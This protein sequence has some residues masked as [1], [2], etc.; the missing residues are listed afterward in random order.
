[1]SKASGSY[2]SLVRGVSQQ[3]P[4]D[5]Q[6]G[7]H[8]EMV[9]MIP[10]PVKGLSRRH[11][12]RWQAEKSLGLDGALIAAY[13]TDTANW[14]TFEYSNAGND[15]V[16]LVRRAA[17]PGSS[18]LHPIIG[19]NRTTKTFLSYSRNV[20][21]TVLDL[22][23]NGGVSAITA[24]GK[25]V[26][27]AGHTIV[28]HATS[29]DNWASTDNQ[30]NAVIW[31]RGGA[32]ART[33]KATVTKTDN[34][35]ASFEYTTP[36]ASYPGTLDTT[37]VPVWIPDTTGSTAGT[38]P[39]LTTAS[40]L[41]GNKLVGQTYTLVH[42]AGSPTSPLITGRKGSGDSDFEYRNLVN[43][44]DY[45][46]NSG[47][48]TITFLIDQSWD[49]LTAVYQWTAGGTS[50]TIVFATETTTEAAYIKLQTGYGVA[51]LVYK[52][53]NPTALTVHHGA[54]ALTNVSPAQPSAPSEYSWDAGGK[55]IVFDVS[56]VG[57]LLVSFAYTHTKVLT[58]PNYAK[59]VTDITNAF[60]T[61]VTNWIGTSAEAIQPNNIAESLRLAA[62]AAGM[63]GATRDASTI[64]FDNVK[65]V[66]VNDG[67]DGTL[68]RGVANE[69]ASID[70]VSDIHMIGKIVRIKARHSEEV[71]YLRAE[72]QDPAITS[73]Y[74]EVTWVEAAG[75]VHHID[76][77][78]VY[79]TVIG[80]TLHVASS[81]TLLNVLTSGDTPD[82]VDSTAGD[83]NSA[84][85]PFFI[86]RKIS[87][88]GV[89]QDRLVVGA[90]AVVRCSRIS[91][92]LNFFQSSIVTVL[93]NDPLE[94]LSQGSED[95]ELRYSALYDRDLVIFGKLRQYIISG[96]VALTPTSANMQVMSSLS[97][98]A[99]APPLAVANV[100]FYG[101]I[102]EKSS[103][104]HQIQ[105]GQ[106]AE[107]P[108]SFIN[109]SQID[110]YLTGS[111]IELCNHAKPT[112][113]FV[114]TSGARN[115]VFCFSYLEKVGE[116]RVQDAWGR[117]DF[118]ATLGPVIGMSRTPDGLLVYRLQ[119]GIK[120]DA[121]GTDTWVVADLCPLT[122]GL[123]LY[124][125]LDSIRP[126]SQ[127]ATDDQAV[128]SA[129]LGDYRIAFDSTSDFRFIGDV[130][131]SAD[132]LLAEFPDAT[133]PQVGAFQDSYFIPTNPFVRDRNDKAITQ[134][135]LTVTAIVASFNDTSGYQTEI[136]EG[137]ATE[138][139]LYNGRTMGDINDNIG[140]EPVTDALQSIP[141]GRETRQYSLLIRARAWMP[142][143]LTAL[144]W[145][146][147]FFN[148]TQRF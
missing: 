91:D 64:I 25:Y 31:I 8:T 85:L 104:V 79:A 67:G 23:E 28:P 7:Q 100:I 69:V 30:R 102:G 26:F 119:H 90:G 55:T 81:A 59:Q 15:F 125:Y 49:T 36:V 56:M 44:V 95:D 61:A 9:N 129:S 113:L 112:H 98:A 42:A 32:Y 93:A 38:G 40:E 70:D 94:M 109:S 50:A 14:Q 128:H 24:I 111:L 107:S 72:T 4:Q 20:T 53:W 144:E 58:N 126:W 97:N 108:E 54:E 37:G 39:T 148:R 18:D 147:Q 103:S 133:G 12:S 51:E 140:R 16:L 121:S 34:T 41:I 138:V 136:T 115:S 117:W 110:T 43:G 106:V 134:G 105:P 77:A 78:L 47:T 66:I 124:P 84:P 52:D 74:T 82:Y 99:E 146:G 29:T 73:G 89:F 132:D 71:F 88:L 135:N 80:T 1:M 114:R 5:R 83:A 139:H 22:L 19:Y 57:N 35:Q 131:L 96:R 27:M 10:D 17:R 120:G 11:G 65:A 68:I 48:S 21:D 46:Y 60:N 87:Y 122:T 145:V 75:T 116:G 62:V 63:S 92:Y 3:V 142:F 76:S 86:G 130:L 101:Q 118:N 137:Q 45:T 6:A 141:I 13:T 123:A 2:A 33:F 143:T 127:V